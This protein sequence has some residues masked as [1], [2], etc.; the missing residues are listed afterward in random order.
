MKKILYFKRLNKDRVLNIEMEKEEK[1]AEFI[2]VMLGDG[3][4]GIYDFK[5]RNKMNKLHQLK[6][7]LDS[8]NQQYANYVFNLMKEVLDIEPKIHFKKTENAVDIRVFRKEKVL[9]ALNNI[10]L[11][12]SPKWGNME[13]PAGYHKGKLGL[14]VLKGLFDTDGCVTI[15]N[16]NGIIYPRIE[17]RLCP[18]PA[19][20]QINKI[21]D[22]F[23][24]KYKIQS[25]ERGKTKIRISGKN[26]LRKWFDLV[27]SSNQIHIL[28]ANKFL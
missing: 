18:S 19:Q 11:K 17:I 24:F 6:V 20:I 27:G 1:I 22:E 13:I 7:T 28:K 25:L 5:S 12:I 23:G 10:G 3:S 2:G 21:L 15:F 16:N 4:I 14:L 26:E 8:R 9:H